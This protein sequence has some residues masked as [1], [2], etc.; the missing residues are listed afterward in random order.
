MKLNIEVE[1]LPMRAEGAAD[2]EE[3]SAAILH[4]AVALLLAEFHR[5]NDLGWRVMSVRR[6]DSSDG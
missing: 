2:P 4:D 3:I 1:V 5:L 6:G